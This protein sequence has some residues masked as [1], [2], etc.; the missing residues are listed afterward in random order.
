MPTIFSHIAVPLALRLG[1]GKQIVSNRLMV[2]G[3]GASILPDADV[4]AFRL[5]IA[6]A[7]SFGHRGVSHSLAFA[8][9]VG[10]VAVMFANHLRT[11][12]R[13]AFT[14]VALAT[15]SHGLLD[16]LTNGGLGVALL[17][18]ASLERY[19]FPWHGIEVSPLSLRRVFGPRGLEVFQ[20]ELVWVWLPCL[21]VGLSLL[22]ARRLYLFHAR[23]RRDL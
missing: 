18:P 6:Y 5:G 15:V 11:T 2:A 23:P 19:F 8:I 21:M 16:M 12:R 1:F 17:W 22:A 20:S 13:I 3:L 14:Y 9:V 7:D 4:L 10:L